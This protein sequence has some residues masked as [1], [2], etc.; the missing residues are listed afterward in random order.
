MWERIVGV[1][2]VGEIIGGMVFEGG[3]WMG[4][5]LVGVGE[6][7]ESDGWGRGIGMGERMVGKVG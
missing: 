5:E 4:L 7:G 2:R 1:L 6:K 3:F